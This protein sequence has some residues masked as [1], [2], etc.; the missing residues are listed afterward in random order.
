MISQGLQLIFCH[1]GELNMNLGNNL[2]LGSFDV[3]AVPA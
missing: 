2:V 1:R 3:A